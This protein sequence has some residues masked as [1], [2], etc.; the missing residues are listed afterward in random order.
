MTFPADLV[1]QASEAGVGAYLVKPP[2]RH[3]ME[4][5]ITIAMARFE[6]MMKLSSLNAELQTRI[7]DLD[8]F[9]HTVAHD[10]QS[11]LSLMIGYAEVLEQDHTTL[12]P[13]KLQTYLHNIARNGRKL[14][15]IVDALLLLA[16]VHKTAVEVAPLNMADIVAEALQRLRPL[17]DEYRPDIRLP[18]IWPQPLGYEPWVEEVWTNYL[19]NAIK[20]GGRPPRIELGATGPV[21][22]MIRFWIQDNGSGVTAEEQAR[23]FTPFTRLDRSRARG[24]GLGLSI[25]RRIVD[26]LGGEVGVESDGIPDRGSTFSFTLPSTSDQND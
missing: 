12:P 5:A 14:S 6:D 1:A 23:L 15:R 22:G 3:E 21:D 4:R 24:Y 26:K 2:G 16:G 10:L 20:Y 19:S 25:V 11:P 9:A 7:E 8:A 17:I 18:D 13:E